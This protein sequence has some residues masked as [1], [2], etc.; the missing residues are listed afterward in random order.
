MAARANFFTSLTLV[1]QQSASAAV[2]LLT[3]P[4]ECALVVAE[5]V[6][7]YSLVV[8]L[9]VL[10]HVVEGGVFHYIGQLLVGQR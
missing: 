8:G 3:F 1:P 2:T 6:T 4:Q 7:W 9:W 10:L 5:Q